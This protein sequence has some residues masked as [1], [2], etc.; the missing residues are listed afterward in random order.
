MIHNDHFTMVIMLYFVFLQIAANMW[1][2]YF[3]EYCWKK[4][5]RPI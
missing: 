1:K 3:D 4:M 2:S 5:G